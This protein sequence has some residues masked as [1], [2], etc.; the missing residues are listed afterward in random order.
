M[1]GGVVGGRNY[2]RPCTSDTCNYYDEQDK[3]EH[4]ER[5]DKGIVWALASSVSQLE[6]EVVGHLH[7]LSQDHETC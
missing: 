7:A 5:P 6:I 2:D 3:N 4:S 1:I